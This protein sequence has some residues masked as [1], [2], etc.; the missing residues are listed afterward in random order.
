MLR[1][2]RAATFFLMQVF[3]LVGGQSSSEV[4]ASGQQHV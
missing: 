1:T 3:A 2:Q 4:N